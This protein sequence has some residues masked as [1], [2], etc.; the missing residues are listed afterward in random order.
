M[1]AA[2]RLGI[3]GGTFNPVHIGHLLMA[4]DAL[5]QVTL[6]QVLLIPC[7]IPPHKQAPDLASAADR[8]AMLRAAIRGDP[9]FALDDQEI[10][11]GPP[12]FT[13]AVPVRGT[14]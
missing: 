13:G 1:R 8:L 4:R 5:E 14:Q 3:L 9:H 6:D 7:A 10:R 2:P 12:S 11:R